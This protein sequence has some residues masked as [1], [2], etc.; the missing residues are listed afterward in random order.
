MEPPAAP[1]LFAD[2]GV[3]ARAV[4]C[5]AI[6]LAVLCTPLGIRLPLY[7]F[8]LLHDPIRQYI[9]EWQP[10]TGLSTQIVVGMF[11][12]AAIVLY[13][14][15][16]L[17]RERPRDFVLTFLMLGWALLSIRNIALFA[18]VAAVPASLIVAGNEGWEDP[19]E[20]RRFAALR[21]LALVLVPLV[22][23]VAYHARPMVRPWT[24]PEAS[25]SQ[26]AAMPGDH[27]L[28]CT[29]FSWCAVALGQPNVRV[30]LDG[31]ADPYPVSVWQSFAQFSSLSP[32][33]QS[34]L[35][36]YR[37]NAVLTRRDSPVVSAMLGLGNWR[38]APPADSCCT[39][40]IRKT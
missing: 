40:L 18:I 19:L 37:V 20:E 29:E 34:V 7:A 38:E 4:L 24:P 21:W 11:P 16:R 9:A 13:G 30:F 6:P 5:V 10:L 22:G 17:W 14:V 15:R 3:R 33:W 23:F 32:G 26:L 28:L 39:L 25:I 2:P 35:D 8:M 36:R 12:L 31:R 1:N 27:R